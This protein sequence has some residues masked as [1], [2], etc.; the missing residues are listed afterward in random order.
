MV[1]LKVQFVELAVTSAC[2]SEVAMMSES[3]VDLEMTYPLEKMKEK[4]KVKEKMKM[5]VKKKEKEKMKVKEKV[6]TTPQ[7]T[8]MILG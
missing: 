7:L 5:K 2:P 1:A 8:Q 4:V 3:W 6:R